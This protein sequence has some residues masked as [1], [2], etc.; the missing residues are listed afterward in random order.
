[1]GCLC[2][3][4]IYMFDFIPGSK[5]TSPVSSI[6]CVVSRNSPVDTS[7]VRKSIISVLFV[8]QMVGNGIYGC[9][10]GEGKEK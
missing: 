10:R 5:K 7:S 1:M 9:V 6:N 4:Y 3:L 8:K 2:D